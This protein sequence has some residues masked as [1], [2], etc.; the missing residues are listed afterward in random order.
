MRF[1]ASTTWEE[2]FAG[3]KLREANDPGWIKCA[4]EIKG[5]PDWESW[6]KFTASQIGAE[7]LNWELYEFSDPM[8][9]IPDILLGPYSGWQSRVVDKNKNTFNDLILIPE[10]FE[11]WQGINKIKSIIE[12]FPCYTEM[13]GLIRD[14]NKKIVCLEGHHRA[15]AVAIVAKL[16]KVIIFKN[17][18]KIALAHIPADQVSVF[19]KTLARGSSNNQ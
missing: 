14:D 19:D 7:N 1:I 4:T 18:I 11:Y 12:D 17:P 13:I 10:Q 16:G 9:E 8:K 15:T 3:W 2:V 5:W 6:R